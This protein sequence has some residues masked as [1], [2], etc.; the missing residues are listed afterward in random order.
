MMYFG[1]CACGLSDKLDV[2]MEW[3][4]GACEKGWLRMTPRFLDA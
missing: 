2:C 3:A 1:E 4:G